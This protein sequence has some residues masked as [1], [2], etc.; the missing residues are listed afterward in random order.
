MK[1]LCG[2]LIILCLALVGCNNDGNDGGATGVGQPSLTSIT[3]SQIS[4][5]QKNN[6]A[7]LLGTNLAGVTSVTLGDDIGV[8]SFSSVSA[9]EISVTFSVTGVATPGPRTITVTTPGGTT[10]N[11]SLLQVIN[12]HAPIA[13]FL[14]D[15]PG[16]TTS[17][18]FTFDASKSRDSDNDVL[19][20]RWDFGGGATETGKRVTH[21]F[22]SLGSYT[23]RLTVHD[24]HQATG[25][26]EVEVEILK[27]SPPV[28]R[29]TVSEEKPT[30]GSDVIFDA[31]SSSD[32]DGRIVSFHWKFGDDKSANGE[33]VRHS[34]DKEGTYTVQLTVTD[35]KGQEGSSERDLK[36][37]KLNGVVCRSHEA[38]SGPAYVLDVITANRT[39]HELYVKFKQ[40]YGC[41]PFYKCGD[42]RK[43]GYPG[44][45]P[46]PEYWIGTMCKF[47]DLGGGYALITTEKGRYWPRDGETKFY[48][49]PQECGPLVSP[50][51]R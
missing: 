43:G 23:V 19:G 1:Q 51:C 9:N 40:D 24:S 38:K 14:V 42:I 44:I 35:N 8:H 49:W 29:F 31:S 48:A 10:T 4:V 32:P 16:G 18:T 5:M 50:S 30:T 26:E 7:S 39:K 11:S 28:P 27:N 20:Y 37:E 12:N 2:I 6:V 41:T 13:K 3:P 21:M 36:V 25:T 45:S 33:V 47:I 22:A 17:T 46:G 34:Y 15:P